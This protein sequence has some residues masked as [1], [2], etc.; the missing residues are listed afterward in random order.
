MRISDWSS[1][2][3]SS[4]L[5]R[6]DEERGE[7]RHALDHFRRL[8]ADRAKQWLQNV[9]ER[10]LTDQAQAQGGQGDT[11]LTDRK[12]VG[13]GKSVYVRVHHGGCLIIKRQSKNTTQIKPLNYT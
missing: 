1:D 4:D 7:E 9:G 5:I 10:R 8:N 11:Q 3:C 13:Q 2:V 6:N 12:S